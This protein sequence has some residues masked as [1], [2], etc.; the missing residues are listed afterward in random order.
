MPASRREL[1]LAGI[2]GAAALPTRGLAQDPHQAASMQAIARR[3]IPSTGE[4]LPVV[5]L[6]TSQTL[7]VDPVAENADL[8]TVMR[9]FLALG[10]TLIDSSPMYR[11][12]EAVVGELLRRVGRDDVF[13]ATKVWTKDGREA[14]IKQMQESAEKMGAKRIDL[15]QVHNLTGLDVQLA[16]LEE[17]KAAGKIRYLGVT[18]MRDWATVEK[19]MNERSLD[20]IQ[21]PY[22]IGVRVVEE[23]ILPT[24]LDQGVA[25]LVMRPFE[26]GELFRKVQGKPLP[27]WAADF[28]C[29][30]WAQFFLKWLLGHPAITCPIPATSKPHHLRDNMAAGVGRMPDAPTR[31]KM[32]ELVLG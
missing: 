10:G 32:A 5:G 29:T 16:T 28:D 2:A 26:R 8:V 25:V 22:S 12:A 15:M 14:G 27:A 4:L 11:R 20:F 13:Y 3:R 19:L 24:A 31:K 18:E 23:R 1:F 17:W 30:S 21:I 6:G 9:E 7:D